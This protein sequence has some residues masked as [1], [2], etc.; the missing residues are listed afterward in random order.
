[1]N[2]PLAEVASILS[3]YREQTVAVGGLR[4]A[5]RFDSDEEIRTVMEWIKRETSDHKQRL[6][7]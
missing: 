4:A 6:A 2:P 3:R 5:E 1:M 7:K